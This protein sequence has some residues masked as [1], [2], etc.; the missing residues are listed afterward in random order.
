MPA[1][2]EK[3]LILIA[4]DDKDLLALVSFRLEVA[5]YACV[6]AHDGE[7][8]LALAL[9]HRPVLAVFDVRM[10]KLDGLG[11]TRS[12][13]A[14]EEIK[15]TPV[16]L[17]SASVQEMDVARGFDVGADDYMKKPFSPQE[18]LARIQTLLARR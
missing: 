10:P 2:E 13:R 16:I 9:E 8:A 17:L 3:P 1:V 15:D 18:L 14:H 5:G 11:L 4:D 6:A 12:I 7:E